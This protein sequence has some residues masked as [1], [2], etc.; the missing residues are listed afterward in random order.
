MLHGVV[1][2]VASPCHTR[3]YSVPHVNVGMSNVII[4]LFH[5]KTG[6]DTAIN[7]QLVAVAV[8]IP[9]DIDQPDQTLHHVSDDKSPLV[10]ILLPILAVFLSRTNPT[11]CSTKSVGTEPQ[12]FWNIILLPLLFCKKFCWS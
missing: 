6:E 11:G 12:E 4:Y 2:V 5:D 10:I 9:L 1:K 3:T 8:A 7:D